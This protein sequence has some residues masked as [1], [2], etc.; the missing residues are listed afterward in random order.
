MPEAET[1]SA[2]PKPRRRG[3][4]ALRF[5]LRT[6]V[7]L[8]LL[9]G[10]ASALTHNWT[11]WV[12][13]R[14]FELPEELGGFWCDP[15]GR[16]MVARDKGGASLWDLRT[17][18]SVRGEFAG[19]SKDG[20]RAL[21]IGSGSVTVWDATSRVSIRQIDD[22]NDLQDV[23]IWS[24]SLSPGGDR[25]TVGGW[26]ESLPFLRSYDVSTGRLIYANSQSRFG[27]DRCPIHEIEIAPD[28]ATALTLSRDAARI[29]RTSD[30]ESLCILSQNAFVYDAWYSPNGQYLIATG[31]ERE[32]ASQETVHVW[33]TQDW[34]ELYVVQVKGTKLDLPD[35]RYFAAIDTDTGILFNLK[36][37]SVA[38]TFK[39]SK[40]VS[41]LQISPDDRQLLTQTSDFVGH[42]WDI[43]SGRETAALYGFDKGLICG[44]EFSTDG[45]RLVTKADDRTIRVWDRMNGEQLAC[46]PA[47]QN[48]QIVF[49]PDG[50]S[51]LSGRTPHDV[52]IWSRRRPEYAWGVACLPEF[53]LTIVFAAAL[54]WSVFRD[55]KRINAV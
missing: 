28:G 27:S 8:V 7:I 13:T 52:C 6:L 10:S 37:G 51:I 1:S 26:L 35:D 40:S 23:R 44:A 21:S 9:I 31:T 48:S 14:T 47:S 34:S 30:G 38:R 12:E 49:L 11:P 55:R 2:L 46:I 16:F 43:E 4:P 45:Q 33:N 22:L 29:W 42:V 50:R 18:Q 20:T 25:I 5:S 24:A 15:T 3:L 41:F 19:F 32:N 54:V 39:H 53:W 36:D 17:G